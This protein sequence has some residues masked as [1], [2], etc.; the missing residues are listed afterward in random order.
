M[1]AKE[2]LAAIK[3]FGG[4]LHVEG[5]ELRY[6]GPKLPPGAPIRVEIARHKAE[7]MALCVTKRIKPIETRYK[8][9]RF[10]SRLEARWAVYF[11]ALGVEW[12]YE[13][14]GFDLEDEGAYL[15]DFWLKTVG[16]WAEVKGQKFTPEEERRCSALANESG[17]PVL[18]LPGSPEWR[19]YFAYEVC[20]WDEAQCFGLGKHFRHVMWMDY[21][22][23]SE[24]LHE[25]RFYCVSGG[26]IGEACPSDAARAIQAARSARFE[27]GESGPSA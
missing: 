13:P 1:T 21:T 23:T 10:R 25:S 14:Q 17:S 26:L 5:G 22:L 11:D 9:Y 15:P 27:H 18:M 2:V 8:G 16:M 6:R 3:S 4:S 20:D 7:L 12:E 19:S 24:F